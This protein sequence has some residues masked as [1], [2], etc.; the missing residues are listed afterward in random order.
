MPLNI[1]S[2]AC[3]SLGFPRFNAGKACSIWQSW[4]YYLA[5]LAGEVTRSL[6]R[7]MR[8]RFGGKVFCHTHYAGDAAARIGTFGGSLSSREFE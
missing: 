2:S 5:M 7:G 8:T 6:E 3:A 1:N 4:A